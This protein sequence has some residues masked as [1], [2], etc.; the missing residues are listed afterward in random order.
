M[1]DDYIW[2]TADIEYR[3][4]NGCKGIYIDGYLLSVMEEEGYDV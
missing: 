4:V 2:D 1:L 3:Q